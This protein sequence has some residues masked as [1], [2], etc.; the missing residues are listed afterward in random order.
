[1]E[2]SEDE[3]EHRDQPCIFSEF[4]EL[5]FERQAKPSYS[6]FQN[7]NLKKATLIPVKPSTLSERRE[8]SSPRHAKVSE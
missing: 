6:I 5:M 7:M 8:K 4:L 2:P 3:R 1:M